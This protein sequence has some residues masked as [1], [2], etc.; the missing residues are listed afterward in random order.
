M[1][2]L[3]QGRSMIEMLGVL[4][5]I[6]VLSIGGLAGYTMAMNRHKANN[7]LDFAQKCGVIAQTQGDGS[8]EITSTSCNG[9]AYVGTN[10]PAPLTAGDIKVTRAANGITVVTVP[11]ASATD[12]VS[13]ALASRI[14]ETAATK[15]Y[16]SPD[17]GGTG[18]STTD[19]TPT[20]N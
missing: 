10:D 6:G 16:Y 8:K 11:F 12:S 14:G 9:T 18:W 1:K 3:Q 13:E 19:P 20:S 15:Y 2:K 5:I 17:V 7:I 4:A